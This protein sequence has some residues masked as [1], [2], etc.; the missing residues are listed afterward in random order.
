MFW[1]H[2]VAYPA[3]PALYRKSFAG[4]RFLNNY[5]LNQYLHF[6]PIF[7]LN[8]F[9]HLGTYPLHSSH[10]QIAFIEFR[11]YLRLVLKRLGGKD[12]QLAGVAAACTPTNNKV[13]VYRRL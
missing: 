11:G 13:N 10:Y 2:P 7:T 12:R 4:N 5:S 1:S 9:F 8:I 3:R 6:Y